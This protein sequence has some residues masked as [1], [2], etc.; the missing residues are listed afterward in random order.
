MNDY[1]LKD[2]HFSL[3]YT[4]SSPSSFF[5]VLSAIK[6]SAFFCAFVSEFAATASYVLLRGGEEWVSVREAF[7]HHA[8]AKYA[9]SP[10]EVDIVPVEL[11]SVD[12]ETNKETLTQLILNLTKHLPEYTNSCYRPLS[13][14]PAGCFADEF[15]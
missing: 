3:S 2:D 1:S 10:D 9:A 11:V 15:S 4:F 13:L 5:H 12:Y 8:K 14:E 6:H 7:W